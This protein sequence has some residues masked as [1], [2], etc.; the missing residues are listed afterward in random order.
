MH[1]AHDLLCTELLNQGRDLAVAF[2]DM[3]PRTAS[4]SLCRRASEELEDWLE[5]AKGSGLTGF[6]SFVRGIHADYAA[7]KAAFS[8]EWSNTVTLA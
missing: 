7:V 5:S 3:M 8:L 6:S 2:K 1:D 4:L